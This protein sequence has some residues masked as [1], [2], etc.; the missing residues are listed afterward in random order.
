MNLFKKV[1]ATIALTTLVATATVS[2]VS[3]Y[4]NDSEAAAATLAAKG[5]I[6]D[7]SDNV[8]AYELGN[9]VKRQEVAA[10]AFAVAGLTKKTTCDNEYTDVTATTP[11]TWA[12]YVVEALRDNGY[13]AKNAKFRI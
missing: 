4:T 11:N 8:A 7:H 6:V 10:V 1:I 13:L 2:S 3:A 12:C 9:L 5:V